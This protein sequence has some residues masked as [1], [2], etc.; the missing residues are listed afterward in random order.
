MRTGAV[1]GLGIA[2]AGSARKDINDL[3]TPILE[4]SGASFELVAHAGLS[5]G[6]INIASCDADAAQ[7]IMQTMLEKDEATLNGPYAKFLMLGLGLLYLGKQGAADL[8]LEALKAIP[9]VPGQCA[10]ATVEMCAYAGTGNV[11]KVQNMLHTCS[12]HLE[13]NNAH[14]ALAVL[15]ISL[16]A[17]GEELGSEMVLRSFD[18]LLQYGE[19]TIRRAVPLALGLISVSY[20][21]ISV[22]DTLSKLSHD[23]DADV[24]QGAIL[25]LGLIGAGSNNARIAGLLRSLAQY[26]YKDANH[27]FVVRLA[28]G[29]LHM[30]K[31]TITLSP[32]HSDRALMSPVAV[33]G[34][35]VVLFAALDLKNLLLSK[36]HYLLYTLVNAMFPRMLMTLDEDLKPINVPVR[37]GQAVDT[38]GQAGKPK[39]ITGFQTHTTP[40]LLGYLE[41]AELATDDYI[42]VTS[43]L[44]G[45]TILKPNPNAIPKEFKKDEKKK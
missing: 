10:A 36:A 15:G 8:T 25:S 23:H 34:L 28:Q 27:L 13:E 20:P 43:V 17:M 45:F 19:P 31:G 2:Y 41:R 44:E 12:D 26:Y 37:V 39:T 11:L 42:P 5:L 1:L 16:V 40:V 4:D 24:A 22:V 33:S 7:G 29:F 18:H 3:L 14:Q 9:G 38:V 6:M 30:G 32:F 21:R 35:L